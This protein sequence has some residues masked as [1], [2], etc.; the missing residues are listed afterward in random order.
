LVE[1]KQLIP[2]EAAMKKF[3]FLLLVVISFSWF[4]MTTDAT[5]Q[6]AK[7]IEL[8]MSKASQ[9]Q[10]EGLSKTGTDRCWLE[11]TGISA[12]KAK[13]KTAKSEPESLATFV[14]LHKRE[15]FDSR[16]LEVCRLAGKPGQVLGGTWNRKV[17]KK[18]Q[19]LSS[20][21]YDAYGNPVKTIQEPIETVVISVNFRVM[22]TSDS[23]ATVLVLP[24]SKI[25]SI[26]K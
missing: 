9:V 13:S 20:T 11:Y 3:S 7:G 25:I 8:N 1:Y 18:G 19:I 24:D 15:G 26:K 2:R 12:S 5:G 14:L 17:L 23:E 10:I 22:N 6:E 4:I 21:T 16:A